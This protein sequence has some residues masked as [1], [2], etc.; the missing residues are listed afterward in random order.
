MN[1]VKNHIINALESTPIELD[2]FPHKYIK[3]IFPAGFYKD[4]IE[5]LPEKNKYD[6]LVKSGRVSSNYS[7]ERFIFDLLVET[8][9]SKLD[10]EKRSFWNN[11]I[12][13]ITSKEIYNSTINIFRKIIKN[14]INNF[15]SEEK[16]VLGTEPFKFSLKTSLIKD[17]TKYNLGSHTD[18][19]EKLITFLFYIPYDDSLI[20]TGTCLYKLKKNI[21]HDMN[22]HYDLEETNKFF[23]KVKS[24]KFLPNTLLLF[25]R[26][27]LSY[28][29]VDQINI[30]QKERNLLLLNYYIGKK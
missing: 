13:I 28:H 23:D 29:G 24:C 14:R 20:N 10:K 11:V 18:T 26:T 8:S 2:P 6:S 17:F 4:L 12:E 9:M 15:T 19:L 3:D 5:N 1:S 30:K 25:P 27:N 22:D 7:S 16:N 21:S